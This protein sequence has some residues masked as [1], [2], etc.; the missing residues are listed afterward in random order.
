MPR[1]K[2]EID[3]GS[4]INDS[5]QTPRYGTI[6]THLFEIGEESTSTFD[7]MYN[8][9]SRFCTKCVISFIYGFCI[10]FTI[11]LCYFGL[12]YMNRCPAK[13]QIPVYLLISGA[14]SLL[15]ISLIMMRH[16][17][18]Q[19]LADEADS[20]GI[21]LRRNSE[22]NFYSNNSS[23]FAEYIL[24]IILFIWFIFG[25]VWVFGSFRPPAKQNE[26]SPTPTYWCSEMVYNLAFFQICFTYAIIFAI[27]TAMC[28]FAFCAPKF[29]RN[30][31]RNGNRAQ[32]L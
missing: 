30:D 18:E 1:N 12:V 6:S 8:F 20:V 21:G 9:A 4:T 24:W 23:K 5:L 7:F 25:N 22:G 11:V 31:S 32:N 28:S 13:K 2:Q 14:V 10:L 29:I 17:R 3:A 19:D 26:R 15:Q 27:L 16:K